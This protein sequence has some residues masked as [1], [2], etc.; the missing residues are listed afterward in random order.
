MPEHFYIVAIGTNTLPNHFQNIKNPKITKTPISQENIIEINNI[1]RENLYSPEYKSDLDQLMLFSASPQIRT[2]NY[3]YAYTTVLFV[4]TLEPIN[5]PLFMSL[6]DAYHTLKFVR[7][8][9]FDDVYDQAPGMRFNN[10]FK[11]T[12]FNVDSENNI[13]FNP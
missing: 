13:K 6:D 1:L 10:K 4:R 11:R 2:K 5:N 3:Y 7:L 12:F 9:T 8:Y